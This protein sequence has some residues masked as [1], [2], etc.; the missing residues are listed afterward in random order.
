MLEAVLKL[1]ENQSLTEISTKTGISYFWLRRVKKGSVK[2]PNLKR[3][4][5][6]YD[7]LQKLP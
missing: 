5:V 6:L 3:L 1:L 2:S 7:Y 4:E